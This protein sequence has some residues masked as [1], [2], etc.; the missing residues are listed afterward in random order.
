MISSQVGTEDRRPRAFF[1]PRRGRAACSPTVGPAESA[2]AAADAVA[3][4]AAPG[5]AVGRDARGSA[6]TGCAPAEWEA[7]D[8]G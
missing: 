5:F 1:L 8:S 6:S 4:S 3:G 7:A 2:L